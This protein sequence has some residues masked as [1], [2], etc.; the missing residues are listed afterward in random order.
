MCIRDSIQLVQN[1]SELK[2]L[3]FDSKNNYEKLHLYRMLFDGK[4]KDIESDVI[5]KFI[6]EAFHI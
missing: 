4:A 1:D 2:K 3:Y 6:N 5:R